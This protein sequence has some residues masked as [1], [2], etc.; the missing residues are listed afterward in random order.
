MTF[1]FSL[2][3]DKPVIYADTEFDKGPYDA[4]W[5]D[6]PFWTMTALPRI[7]RKLTPDNMDDLKNMIDRCL[8]DPRYAE[9]RRQVRQETWVYPG[10]GARRAADYLEAKL[11]E[12]T[13]KEG[14]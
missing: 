14:A 3:Y 8:T 9:G 13:A 2:V 1:D 4:W 12:L 10:E 11:R 6:T 5:L 7:G